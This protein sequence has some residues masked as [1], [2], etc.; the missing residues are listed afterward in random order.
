MSVDRVEAERLYISSLLKDPV[1]L[2]SCQLTE[3]MFSKYRPVFTKLL[4]LAAGGDVTHESL[5]AYGTDVGFD[6]VAALE[7]YTTANWELWH[8]SIF[9]AWAQ[10]QVKA[11]L[12][13]AGMQE[14]PE[15]LETIEKAMTAVMLCESGKRTKR[16][17]ELLVPAIERVMERTKNQGKIPGIPFGIT[18]VDQATLGAQPGRL[19]VIGARPSQGK[20]A[21]MGQIAR[22]MA[23]DVPVGIFTVESDENEL[24]TRLIAAEARIDGRKLQTGKLLQSDLLSLREAGVRMTEIKDRI[25]VHDQPGLKLSQLQTVARRMVKDGARVLFLDYLQLV[26]VP[27]KDSRREEVAEVSTS[28]KALARELDVCIVALAQLGRDSDDKRPTMGDC[29]HSSQIEQD[30]DQVWLIW[31]KKNSEGIVTESRL[32]LDKVRD[33]MTRDVLVRFDR[34]ILTFFEI[35]AK[36]S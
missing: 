18:S 36:E 27:G 19:V 1:L 26:R 33:G 12:H 34:P 31:H 4:E 6:L 17:G 16:I 28:L 23:S 25:I 30:A 29:Q 11:A 24:M 35:Q 3:A 9:E 20:S 8:K 5:L 14:Y 21:L 32:I 15:N 7:P 22:S 2:A 10:D 13:V